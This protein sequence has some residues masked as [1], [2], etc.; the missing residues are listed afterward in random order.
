LLDDVA[1]IA[2]EP[3]ARAEVNP[4]L[5]RLGIWVGLT[6]GTV[7]KGPKRRV[8]RLLSGRM[9]FGD[10]PLPVPLFGAR[11]LEGGPHG[12]GREV[13]LPSGAGGEG[14]RTKSDV[15]CESRAER[16]VAEGGG[17]E[18]PSAAPGFCDPAL[19]NESQPEGISI[20]KVS[21]GDRRQTFPNESGGQR[22]LWLA[23]S[24]TVEFEADSFLRLGAAE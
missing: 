2:S 15:V 8:Q 22:L 13:P 1:R 17:V 12:G 18:P 7:V 9:T 10:T 3:A 5:R 24:Q 21:R 20:T 14:V 11:H 16:E 19:P 4:L 6:F 23:L